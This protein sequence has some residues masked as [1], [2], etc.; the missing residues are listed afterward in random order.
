MYASDL[1]SLR[2][3]LLASGLKP[4]EISYPEYLPNGEFGLSDPDGYTLMIAQ[5]GEDTP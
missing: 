1:E 5:G 3:K 4:G 2:K